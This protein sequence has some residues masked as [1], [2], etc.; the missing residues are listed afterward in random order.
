MPAEGD[1]E[2]AQLIDRVSVFATQRAFLQLR[3]AAQV[4]YGITLEDKMLHK[5]ESQSG[6]SYHCLGGSLQSRFLRPRGRTFINQA[7]KFESIQEILDRYHGKIQKRKK[8][9]SKKRRLKSRKDVR[10]LKSQKVEE[11]SLPQI[12]VK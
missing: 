8:T 11:C 6:N 2:F 1:T 4:R 5:L 7:E 3:H 12:R 10:F 9:N